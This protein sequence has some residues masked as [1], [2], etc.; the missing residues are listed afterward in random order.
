[1]IG[2]WVFYFSPDIYTYADALDSNFNDRSDAYLAWSLNAI[3][4]STCERFHSRV[5][6]QRHLNEDGSPLANGRT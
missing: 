3:V 5:S 6:F 4:G 1:M 2:R